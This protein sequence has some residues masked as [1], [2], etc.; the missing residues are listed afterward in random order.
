VRLAPEE[1]PEYRV[2]VIPWL[3]VPGQRLLVPNWLAITI[4][5]RIFAWRPL[6]QAELAHEVTHVGQW[7]RY[8][9]LFVPRYLR[10]SWRARRAGGDGYRD[11]VFEREAYD[12]ADAVRRGES[13]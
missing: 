13:G 6:D 4:G 8:G 3:R 9:L 10:A 7:R 1:I 5:N 11:N 2:V 12:A